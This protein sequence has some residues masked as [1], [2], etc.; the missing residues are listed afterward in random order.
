MCSFSSAENQGE[1]ERIAVFQEASTLIELHF[2]VM[3]AGAKTE[4]NALNLAAFLTR[5]VLLLLLPLTVQVLPVV[6]NAADRRMNGGRDLKEVEPVLF[7]KGPR[8][9]NAHN[10]ARN[11]HFLIGNQA[12]R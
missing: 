8:L 2:D 7:C 10:A 6:H 9:L 12:D 1:F 4:A 5:F 3:L 11:V